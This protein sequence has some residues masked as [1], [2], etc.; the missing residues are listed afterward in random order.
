MR[1]AIEVA[2]IAAELPSLGRIAV[3]TLEGSCPMKNGTAEA[4]EITR[5]VLGDQSPKKLAKY[6]GGSTD[7]VRRW[8]E[9]EVGGVIDLVAI[10]ALVRAGALTIGDVAR[11]AGCDADAER[12]DLTTDAAE[13]LHSELL[14]AVAESLKV[15]R[16]KVE[17]RMGFDAKRLREKLF[18]Q[19]A[20]TYRAQ[21]KLQGG[22]KE[23]HTF[24]GV[25]LSSLFYGLSGAGEDGTAGPVRRVMGTGKG[26]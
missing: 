22:W 11:L 17:L 2:R 8:Q 1:L 21:D 12:V 10:R 18:E 19:Y 16:V 7:L 6:V 9:G 15:P 25:T 23:P 3:H 13:L 20:A 5:Q 24:A 26:G 14:S 4:K